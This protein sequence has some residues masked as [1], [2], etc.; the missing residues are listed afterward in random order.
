MT[1][2]QGGGISAGN[3]QQQLSSL[4]L[5]FYPE[6]GNGTFLRNIQLDK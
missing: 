1:P 3:N 4:G 5:L 6:D 2:S